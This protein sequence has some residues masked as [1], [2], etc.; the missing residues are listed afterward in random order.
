MSFGEVNIPIIDF[1]IAICDIKAGCIDHRKAERTRCTMTR[2]LPSNPAQ[3]ADCILKIRGQKVMIDAD[4]AQLYG[5]PTK[6]LNEQVRRNENRF[7]GYFFSLR[8][9]NAPRWSQI[10]TTSPG[11]SFPR[12]YPMPSQSMARSW[13]LPC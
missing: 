3:I 8:P 6:R 12:R 9:P 10:A 13:Q 2:P 7:A 11:S 5:V 1:D 4:L